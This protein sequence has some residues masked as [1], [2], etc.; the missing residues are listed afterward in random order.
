[1]WGKSYS[2]GKIRQILNFRLQGTKKPKHLMYG[3]L[4]VLFHLHVYVIIINEI[5]GICIYMDYTKTDRLQYGFI[6]LRK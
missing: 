3:L 4:I 5:V 6:I 2:V 1:M